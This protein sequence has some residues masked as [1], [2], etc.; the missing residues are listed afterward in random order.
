[1][2]ETF[3]MVCIIVSITT[4]V[5]GWT[6]AYNNGVADTERRWHDAVLRSEQIEERIKNGQQ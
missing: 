1:M 4:Y 3:L 5:V 6:D 2:A